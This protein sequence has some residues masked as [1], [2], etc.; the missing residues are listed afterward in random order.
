[1]GA[2]VESEMTW[3]ERGEVEPG[4]CS[5]GSPVVVRPATLVSL[6]ESL[7]QLRV[8]SAVEYAVSEIV[9]S[10]VHEGDEVIVQ[11]AGK[12]AWSVRLIPATR[13][14]AQ[15]WALVVRLLAQGRK[16]SETTAVQVASRL[17]NPWDEC[18]SAAK[19]R[20]N[21]EDAEAD[22]CVA[23][24]V[25]EAEREHAEAELT[26]AR[27][28]KQRVEAEL[29]E[30]QAAL[31]D[32]RTEALV[33][34]VLSE[35]DREH[36]EA[37]MSAELAKETRVVEALCKVLHQRD[38][39]HLLGAAFRRW[40]WQKIRAE[41]KQKGAELSGLGTRAAEAEQNLRSTLDS[42]TR[43]MAR[44]NIQHRV[45]TNRGFV[46][47]WQIRG[48][49]MALRAWRDC[50]AW[51]KHA[52]RIAE[53]SILRISRRALSCAFLGWALRT[54]LAMERRK[55]AMRAVS[56]VGRKSKAVLMQTSLWEWRERVHAGRNER[57]RVQMVSDSERERVQLVGD[58][59][60]TREKLVKERVHFDGQLAELASSLDASIR[61]REGD[62]RDSED[63]ME[64][65]K[66]VLD[67]VQSSMK[68]QAMR[69][70]T[71]RWKK[72]KLRRAYA[73]LSFTCMARRRARRLVA[74][75]SARM[76][77]RALYLAFCGWTSNAAHAAQKRRSALCTVA[78]LSRGKEAVRMTS[79]LRGWLNYTRAE[80]EELSRKSLL[81]SFE[82]EKARLAKEAEEIRKRLEEE[83]ELFVSQQSTSA[84]QSALKAQDLKDEL[85]SFKAQVKQ[86]NAKVFLTRWSNFRLQ[87]AFSALLDHKQCVM[88]ERALLAKAI[89]RLAKG[90][91]S[92]AFL[93]WATRSALDNERRKAAIRVLS[94][95]GRENDAVLL[96][97]SLRGW[98]DCIRA[99]QDGRKRMLM[100]SDF[101]RE[102]VRLL[103]EAEDL[104]VKFDD[105]LLNLKKAVE[106]EAQIALY[107]RRVRNDRVCQN[108]VRRLI[109]AQLSAC[110]LAWSHWAEEMARLKQ[111]A[112]THAE[113]FLRQTERGLLH[114]CYSSWVDTVRLEKA[115][116]AWPVVD[117]G[118]ILVT[119]NS[120][121]KP[122]ALREADVEAGAASKSQ[123]ASPKPR[124]PGKVRRWAQGQVSPPPKHIAVEKEWSPMAFIA[125]LLSP[126]QPKST[127]DGTPDAS[128]AARAP[129]ADGTPLSLPSLTPMTGIAGTKGGQSLT[130]RDADT[131]V[132]VLGDLLDVQNGRWDY[133]AVGKANV[134]SPR[135]VHQV[136]PYHMER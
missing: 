106:R 66:G 83:R 96:Q 85:E 95:M 2:A 127:P 119:H 30:A 77:R 50:C 116:S 104:R 102:K 14:V 126:P 4:C 44:L 132:P 10:T 78:M 130:P 17:A 55:A 69:E 120:P 123:G 38:S 113:V 135:R 35:L 91:L 109:H 3:V 28:G 64:A 94:M 20:E 124:Y 136:Q 29:A 86:H 71:L 45:H 43:A 122:R 52:R 26:E 87:T 75:C 33:A 48:M 62:A 76:S 79:V 63:R 117:V 60:A 84:M 92:R 128:F 15:L 80:R 34:N 13:E 16:V 97:T 27:S 93:G 11:G 129:L 110:I 12:E 105:E 82:L 131:V 1:M 47:R 115:R 39:R 73:T 31:E 24:L 134:A 53:K 67:A 32:A 90:T 36:A 22:A 5:A 61:E 101:E 103:R 125:N 54:A 21:L 121:K 118:P 72:C 9:G 37:E 7:T 74:T 107:K 49:S 46:Q 8:G 89:Q 6:N 65:L 25:A 112:R 108:V 51:R 40:H 114:F 19:A 59:E 99:E 98:R 18:R 111:A 81:T 133:P 88:K 41:R 56:L 58:L 23:N 42:S 100:L 57:E 68:T 70:F